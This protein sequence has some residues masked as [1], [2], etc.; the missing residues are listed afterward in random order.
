M[1][2]FAES[3]L[4]E[5]KEIISKELETLKKD[6]EDIE[7]KIEIGSRFKRII[8]L[9][10]FSILETVIFVSLLYN[11][12]VEMTLCSYVE[13]L[14]TLRISASAE[15]ICTLG[16]SICSIVSSKILIE[17]IKRGGKKHYNEVNPI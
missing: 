6:L 15:V 13:V 14:R 1:F 3:V 16:S 8:K 4:K 11:C 2:E 17:E 9:T 12:I 7:A 5:E 10:I